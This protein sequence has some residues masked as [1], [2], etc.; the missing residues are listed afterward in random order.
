MVK[1]TIIVNGIEEDNMIEPWKIKE[2]LKRWK[3]INLG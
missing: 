3:I 2:E 1:L